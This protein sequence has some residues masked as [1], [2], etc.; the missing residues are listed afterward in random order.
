MMTEKEIVSKVQQDRKDATP[1]KDELDDQRADWI[2]IY[3]AVTLGNESKD[4]GK[5]AYISR[6]V[7]T[8]SEW[9]RSSLVDPFVSSPRPIKCYPIGPEDKPI[10]EQNQSILNYEFTRYNSTFSL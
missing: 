6:D 5:S 9:Q 1:Y 10:A 8:S 4:K 7:K 2:D 3:N